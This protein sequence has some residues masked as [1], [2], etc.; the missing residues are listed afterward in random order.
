M[1]MKTIFTLCLLTLVTISSM[2]ADAPLDNATSN[3]VPVPSVFDK[4][5]N[6]HLLTE[7]GPCHNWVEAT[8]ALKKGCE[9]L[10]TQGGGVIV[11]P[12]GIDP[13]FLPRNALQDI[14]TKAGVL[15]EDYRGGVLRM[16]VLPQGQ[17]SSSA[18]AILLEHM[19][20]LL[21]YYNGYQTNVQKSDMLRIVP[22]YLL[23]GFYMDMDMLCFKNFTISR[24][25]INRYRRG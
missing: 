4:A 25:F 3:A 2:A 11:I 13:D 9:Q 21:P 22:V 15:V 12:Q 14:A 6:R 24:L 16:N 17:P 7:F 5:I 18:D 19:P 10:I 23:G 20:D 8:A 1:P